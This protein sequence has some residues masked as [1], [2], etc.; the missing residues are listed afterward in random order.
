MIELQGYLSSTNLQ[1]A[2]DKTKLRFKDMAK[3][4][5]PEAVIAYE[6]RML[7]EDKLLEAC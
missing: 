5:T 3:F 6:Q 4:V 2:R 1:N 7:D